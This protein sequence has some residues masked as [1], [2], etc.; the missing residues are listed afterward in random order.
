MMN[1]TV[2]AI[3]DQ[4][5]ALAHL[6]ARQPPGQ[7]AADDRLA[8]TFAMRGVLADAAL[9]GAAVIGQRPVHGLDDVAPLAKLFQGRLGPVRD[10]PAARLR[11]GDQTIAFQCLSPADQKVPVLADG[12]AR[13]LSGPQV[14]DALLPLLGDQHLVE[15]RQP[16]GVGF[17]PEFVGKLNL[18]L[19]AQ[20]PSDQFARAVPK[21]CAR[22]SARIPRLRGRP[23]RTRKSSKSSP[24]IS[25]SSK[26][27]FPAA[28]HIGRPS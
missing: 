23:V 28:R 3:D 5:D 10:D 15:P 24:A 13:A 20:F 25:R 21:D 2:Y 11:L 27:N 4:I 22:A 14:D 17:S 8:R 6:V 16:L 9:L 12:I 7:N 1:P 19:M 26:V 18:A